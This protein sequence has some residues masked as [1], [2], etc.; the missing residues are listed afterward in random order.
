MLASGEGCDGSSGGVYSAA[1]AAA[2]LA[3]DSCEDGSLDGSAATYVA[4][5]GCDAITGADYEVGVSE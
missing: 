3:Y 1:A 4:F 5:G 2:G